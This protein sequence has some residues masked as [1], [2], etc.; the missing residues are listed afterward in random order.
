MATWT[1]RT[2]IDATPEEVLGLLTDPEECTRWS[3]ISFDVEQLDCKQLSAGCSARV[4]GELA[5]RRVS[6]DI[7]VIEAGDGRLRLRASGPVD[8]HVEYR[9]EPIA[10]RSEVFASVAIQ[11]RGGFRG[12]LVSAAAD[13]AVAGMLPVAVQRIAAAA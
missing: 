2:T 3:P 13:A 9:A 8:M 4:A 7:D 6:F 11:A 10:D 1:T 12:R 5:G